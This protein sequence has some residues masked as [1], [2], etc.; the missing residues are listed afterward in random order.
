MTPAQSFIK[1]HGERVES[2]IEELILSAYR[3]EIEGTPAAASQF[4]VA[5]ESYVHFTD[6]MPDIVDTIK[7]VVQ[8]VSGWVADHPGTVVVWRIRP[9]LGPVYIDGNE[10]PSRIRLRFR[11]HVLQEIPECLP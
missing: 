2:A 5:Y 4:G 6:I 7:P 9:F 11:A 1:E 3:K 10:H 8:G